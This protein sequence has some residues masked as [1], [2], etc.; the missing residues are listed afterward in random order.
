MQIEDVLEERRTEAAAKAMIKV[1]LAPSVSDI[2]DNVCAIM[3]LTPCAGGFTSSFYLLRLL[4]AQRSRTARRRHQRARRRRPVTQLRPRRRRS[5]RGRSARRRQALRR[6]VLW[7]RPKWTTPR[8]PQLIRNRVTLPQ[9]QANFV[10]LTR[11]HLFI[12]QMF[13]VFIIDNELKCCF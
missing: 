5:L 3:W 12:D 13:N 9:S 7:R 11:L 8:P 10:F 1:A 4:M 6:A 2:G